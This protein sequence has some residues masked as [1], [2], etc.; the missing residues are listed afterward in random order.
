MGLLNGEDSARA[1]GKELHERPR[2]IAQQM[3][4]PD[5]LP[6]RALGWEEREVI[7][8]D[9]RR[10][11]FLAAFAAGVVSSAVVFA[12][13]TLSPRFRSALGVSG[14]AALVVTPTAGS[15]FLSSHLIV[16]KATTDPSN[17]LNRSTQT[18][19]SGAVSRQSLAAWQVAANAVYQNPFK[20]IFGMVIPLYSVI[21]YA[22][23]TNPATAN[24]LLSQRLIH[25][26]VYGQAIAILS[27]IVVMGFC[28]TMKEQGPYTVAEDRSSISVTSRAQGLD[29][30]DRLAVDLESDG[31]MSSYNLL[32]PLLYAPL[33]PLLVI[34]LRNR[35]QRKTLH[36]IVGGTILVA[37]THAGSIMFSDSSVV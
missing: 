22:E 35:V 23:S 30:A 37:L 31:G 4:Q 26:R 14:K 25:T 2:A 17:Y 18:A 20:T 36:C 9:A 12:A 29:A 33:L 28:E 10:S 1:K 15:F 6:S 27:T 21:F 34:T 7:A 24:M 8:V 5:R 19:E 11:G 3:L 16:A 13:N 32:V